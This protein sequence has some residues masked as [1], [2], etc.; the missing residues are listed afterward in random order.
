MIVG[1]SNSL[2]GWKKIYVNWKDFWK[3]TKESVLCPI[4]KSSV[5]KGGMKL[6]Q[7]GIILFGWPWKHRKSDETPTGGDH[8]FILS[9]H[10]QRHSSTAAPWRAP[11]IH[12]QEHNRMRVQPALGRPLRWHETFFTYFSPSICSNHSLTTPWLWSTDIKWQRQ[13]TEAEQRPCTF[14]ASFFSR[15]KTAFQ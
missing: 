10:F 1:V 8:S 6:A 14:A 2:R 13:V 9:L 4:K 5:R 15:R 7:K 3:H 11:R 12:P